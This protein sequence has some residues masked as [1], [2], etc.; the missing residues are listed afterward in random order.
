MLLI[1]H[2]NAREYMSIDTIAQQID[3]VFPLVEMPL[4]TELL[5]D[6]DSLEHCPLVDDIEAFRGK[7]I[8]GEF[9]RLIHREMPYLSAEAWCWILPHY[10]RFCLTPEAEYNRMETEFLIYSLGPDLQLQAET[11]KQLSKFNAAQINCVLN[12]FEWCLA[13]PYWQEFCPKELDQAMN[14]LGKIAVSRRK[15]PLP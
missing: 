10:L 4:K 6:Q 7:K 9:I 1:D 12:F 11:V 2:A 15:L 13:S 8:A 5:F 14:F 3:R